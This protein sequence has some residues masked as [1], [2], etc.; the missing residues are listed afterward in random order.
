MVLIHCS[1]EVKT[2]TTEAS[3][4]LD[5][6]VLAAHNLGRL[7]LEIVRKDLCVTLNKYFQAKRGIKRY[8]PSYNLKPHLLLQSTGT[9]ILRKCDIVK[10][11]VGFS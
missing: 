7:L 2:S 5:L 4:I 11:N 3:S 10:Q 9:Y 1:L 6:I 8:M